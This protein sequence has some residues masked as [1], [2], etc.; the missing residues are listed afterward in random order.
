LTLFEHIPS[1]LVVP[2]TINNSWKMLRYG[3]FPLGIGNH[4]QFK[5]HSALKVNEYEHN[6]LI[7]LIEKQITS[8]IKHD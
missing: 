2:I 4:L 3:K 8:A 7:E 5:V 6:E 1:A